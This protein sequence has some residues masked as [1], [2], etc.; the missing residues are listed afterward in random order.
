[1]YVVLSLLLSTLYGPTEFSN[2]DFS[3]C[4][5]NFQVAPHTQV[6]CCETG[7]FTMQDDHVISWSS[8]L[9]ALCLE[10]IHVDTPVTASQFS[11]P[12][13]I[14]F[15]VVTFCICAFAVAC[16]VFTCIKRYWTFAPREVP[17][18]EV[19]S[20]DG[21]WSYDALSEHNVTASRLRSSTRITDADDTVVSPASPAI[22]LSKL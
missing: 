17:I 2:P 18:S 19:D 1:M 13:I 22:E 5:S 16:F 7:A 15:Y 20:Y 9:P 12:V 21:E 10:S 4:Y 11:L 14:S 8:T 6:Y 3:R